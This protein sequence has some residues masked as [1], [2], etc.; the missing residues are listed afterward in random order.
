[1]LDEGLE[2]AHRVLSLARSEAKHSACE[3]MMLLLTET[4][5]QVLEVSPVGRDQWTGRRSD[6][7]TS[8]GLSWAGARRRCRVTRHRIRRL[9]GMTVRHAC[10]FSWVKWEG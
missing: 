6:R 9:R 1:M 7:R 4:R 8:Q 10:V 2:E 5:P 3:P